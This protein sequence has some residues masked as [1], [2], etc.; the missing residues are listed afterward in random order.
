MTQQPFFFGDV[1]D[2]RNEGRMDL[3][4]LFVELYDTETVRVDLGSIVTVGGDVSDFV[5]GDESICLGI[6]L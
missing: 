3:S 1:V 2:S 6:F 4:G 5:D